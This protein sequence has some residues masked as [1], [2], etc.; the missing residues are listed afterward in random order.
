VPTRFR[1]SNYKPW[2]R[3]LLTLWWLALILGA[4]IYRFG[5]S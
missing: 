3:T 4:A 1:F 2:M 5:T